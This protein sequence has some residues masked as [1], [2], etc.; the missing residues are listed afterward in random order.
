MLNY[1]NRFL[2]YLKYKFYYR[3][4]SIVETKKRRTPKIHKGTSMPGR[5]HK[6]HA[7]GFQ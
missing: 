7:S 5:N 3:R 6:T 2:K 4:V 1:I